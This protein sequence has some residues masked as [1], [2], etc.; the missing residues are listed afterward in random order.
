MT[1]RFDPHTHLSQAETHEVFNQPAPLE[2]YNTYTSDQPLQY[3]VGVYG[4]GW[5]KSQL[6]SFGLQCG[7]DL[8]EAG[9]M[10]NENK[11]EFHT[12]DRFGNRVDLVKFHPSY[13]QLMA[14]AIEAGMHSLPWEQ[15]GPGAQVA[16][17][18]MEYQYFQ[19]D[20][21]S[22]CPLT[23]TFAVVPALKH[24]PKLAEEWLPRI[25]S[26]QYDERNVPYFEKKGVT[27]GMAMTEKQGGS[28]VR[29]NTTRAYPK[30]EGGNGSE[31]EIVGHKW[32]CSAPMSDAFLV[33]AQ[34]DSGL[35]CFLLPRWRDDGSK[36]QFFIQRLKNKLGNASNASSEVEFRGA[37]AWMIGEEGR[38][39]RTIIEM[40]AMTR[41]DCMVG[42]S[43]LMRAA[44]AQAIHHT[45][46]R[47]VFG[48]NLHDQKLMQNVLADLAIESE[49]ALAMSMRVG[50]A[51]DHLDDEQQSLFARITTAVGKYWICKRAPQMI[52]EAMECIGGVG[53]VEDNI[54]PRL[55][56]EAPVNAI[57]EGAGNVQCLD[58]LRAI[59]KEP[60]VLKA[61]LSELDKAKGRYQ[62]YDNFLM[63]LTE[64][65]G[66][67]ET[68][69]YRCRT[70]VE[71]MA[72]AL[73]ACV[74]ICE[75]NK[76]I[77]EAF[78]QSRIARQAGCQFGT[79]PEGIDCFSILKRSQPVI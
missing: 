55:Y 27:L 30:A 46:G 75:G 68:I 23:M 49:A 18:A 77:A 9:F 44:L 70:V 10:A 25:L 24:S 64:E 19:T 13:H 26:H 69:E 42:S 54:L 63:A 36:N 29:A 28:D 58:V 16:R 35:S 40:V 56:R 34:T 71:K 21:G 1:D 76:E 57:W 20:A 11:P 78:V 15:P 6:Q 12:H 22:G 17:A 41:F 48:K 50:F 39:V 8:L 65:L 37:Q 4:A 3:W 33:L 53:Y 60:A 59:N 5:A 47:S 67:H 32:F 73:Q 72:L 62:A 2:Q 79:L 38:G 45:S 51:L 61:Y 14:A 52:V 7:G 31:Y 43:A 74:L 66:N